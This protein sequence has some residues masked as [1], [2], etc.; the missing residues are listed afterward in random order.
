MSIFKEYSFLAAS[1]NNISGITSYNAT[2]NS[3]ISFN[4]IL[5]DT[6]IDFNN[7]YTFVPRITFTS[8]ADRSNINFTIKGY[9][10]GIYIEELIVGPNINTVTSVNAFDLIESISYIQNGGVPPVPGNNF[11]SVGT[12]GVGYFPLIRLNTLK[13]NVT[14]LNYALN[15]MV[16][17]ANPA[18]YQVFLSLKDSYNQGTYDSLTAA[19]NNFIAPAAASAVSALLSYTQLASNILIKVTP[20]ANGTPIK[21]QFMQL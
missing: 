3:L 8:A 12:S 19:N 21:A 16:A 11:V 18:T 17:A 14:N 13:N 9:Q 7:K 2:P 4:G 5:G 15:M 20:N 6:K 10:N 1:T